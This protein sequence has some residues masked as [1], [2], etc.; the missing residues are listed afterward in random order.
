MVVNSGNQLLKA[1]NLIV[2]P[3]DNMVNLNNLSRKEP[4]IENNKV[5]KELGKIHDLL[6]WSLEKAGIYSKMNDVMKL[7]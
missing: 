7:L 6:Y 2:S 4:N 1:K 3:V 5:Y